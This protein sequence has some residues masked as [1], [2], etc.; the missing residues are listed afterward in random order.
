[1]LKTL[2]IAIAPPRY[3]SWHISSPYLALGHK[4]PEVPLTPWV[5]IKCWKL[6]SQYFVNGLRYFNQVLQADV[7][8]SICTVEDD[9]VWNPRWRR[10]P[11]LQNYLPITIPWQRFHTVHLHQIWYTK[12]YRPTRKCFWGSNITFDNVRD[13]GLCI[14]PRTSLWW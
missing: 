14:N 5:P 10:L 4:L 13:G 11:I 12:R 6:F 9:F 1:M 8:W 7:H 2:H 3:I